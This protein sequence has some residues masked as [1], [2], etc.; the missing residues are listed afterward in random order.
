MNTTVIY[1]LKKDCIKIKLIQKIF[2]RI[3]VYFV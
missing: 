3:F 1:F 2:N